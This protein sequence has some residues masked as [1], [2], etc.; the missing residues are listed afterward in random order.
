MTNK[1]HAVPKMSFFGHKRVFWR[2]KSK[3]WR[4]IAI[5]LVCADIRVFGYVDWLLL[6]QT[7]NLVQS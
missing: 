4:E 6:R 5:L 7:S 2:Q 3:F 1:A